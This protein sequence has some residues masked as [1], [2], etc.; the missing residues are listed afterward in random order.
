MRQLVYA[1]VAALAAGAA[2]VVAQ[3]HSMHGPAGQAQ[4]TAEYEAANM[5]MHEGMAI[6]YTG[7]PD[8]DFARSMIPHHEGAIAMAEVELQYGSD[9]ELRKLAEEIIAAQQGEIATL[10]A[11]LKAKGAH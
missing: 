9:P 2:V 6:D 8:V 7:N 3:E 10:Q 4:A 1:V 11:W 5:R